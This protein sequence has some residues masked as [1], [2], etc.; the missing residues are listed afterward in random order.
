VTG[1]PTIKFFPKGKKTPEEYNSGR[2]EASILKFLNDKCGTK[3][4]ITGGLTEEV[5]ASLLHFYIFDIPFYWNE[6]VE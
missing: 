4:T 1:F 3:R 6:N 2:D 5:R